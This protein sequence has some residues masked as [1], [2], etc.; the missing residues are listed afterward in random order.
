[1]ADNQFVTEDRMR[2][3]LHRLIGP[4]VHKDIDAVRGTCRV[5][6]VE[7]LSANDKETALAIWEKL[8]GGQHERGLNNG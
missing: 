5:V 7:T 6:E 1:M 8:F 3:F 4:S 2:E